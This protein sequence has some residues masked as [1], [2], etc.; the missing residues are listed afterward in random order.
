MSFSNFLS[1][2][3]PSRIFFTLN[4]FVDRD[5]NAWSLMPIFAVVSIFCLD[6][7]ITF[8]TTDFLCVCVFRYSAMLFLLSQSLSPPLSGATIADA[9]TMNFQR[10]RTKAIWFHSISRHNQHLLNDSFVF[11]DWLISFYSKC[12][13]WGD[14]PESILFFSTVSLLLASKTHSLFTF[15]SFFKLFIGYVWV[16]EGVNFFF[17]EFALGDFCTYLA[18]K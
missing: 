15:L 4:P 8:N 16:C 17:S 5:A 3:L 13:I 2:F 1:H 18:E 9:V 11:N 6:V 14:F 7:S 12:G 10:N